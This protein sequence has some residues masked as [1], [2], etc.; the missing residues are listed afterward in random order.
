MRQVT[1]MILHTSV[2]IDSAQRLQAIAEKADRPLSR[3]VND[4][5]NDYLLTHDAV[6]TLLA[7]RDK[8]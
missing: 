8:D 1:K 6:A 2:D 5:I 4:A 7:S 3:F